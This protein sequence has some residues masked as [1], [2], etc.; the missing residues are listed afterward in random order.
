[1]AEVRFQQVSKTFP[2]RR[3]KGG[4]VQVLQQLDLQIADGEFLVLVGPSGCGKSTL[5][6]LLA[7]LDQPSS[8]EIYVGERPVSRLRPAQRDV[9]MVFQSYA[10]YPHL[11]VADNIGFGLRRSRPRSALQQLQDSLHNATRGLPGAL[12]VPSKREEQIGRR[13]QPDATEAD[14][15]A[16]GERGLV[17]EDRLLVEGAGALGVLEDQD[18][19]LGHARAGRVIGALDDP[20]AAAVID[21]VSDGLDDLRL[22]DDQLDAEARG[23]LEG[24]GGTSRRESRLAGGRT[25]LVVERF[26]GR[27]DEGR[28][29]RECEEVTHG[30][31]RPAALILRHPYCW[32]R[33]DP[34]RFGHIDNINEGK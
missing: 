19:V 22:A 30:D 12:V 9:A 6:R 1:M 2:P 20:E 27:V 4:P 13:A 17:P 10:L 28:A 31:N 24:G 29:K 11:S 26:V 18:A 33:N 8:G 14:R 3:P 16:A 34:C 25:I 32:Q 7:G 23:D 5:L 21:R 15:D